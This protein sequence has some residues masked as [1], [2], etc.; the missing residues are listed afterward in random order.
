MSLFWFVYTG[1]RIFIS[2]SGGEVGMIKA[3]IAGMK[4]RPA[5]IHML[6]AK[7]AKKIP[8]RMIGRVLSQEEAKGLLGKIV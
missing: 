7:I 4:G 8:K 3:S 1:P 6:D 2:D 5:E